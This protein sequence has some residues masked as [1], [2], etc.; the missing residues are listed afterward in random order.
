MPLKRWHFAVGLMLAASPAFAHGD[1][2]DA[3]ASAR[4]LW[5]LSPEVLL[6]LSPTG[7]SAPV[8]SW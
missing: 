5:Q 1:H 3:D 2:L 8:A 7:A 4:S 6:G